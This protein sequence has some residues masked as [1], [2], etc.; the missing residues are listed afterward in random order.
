M[1]GTVTAFDDHVGLG[2]VTADDGTAYL[3]HC[4][5]IADGSRTIA[6]GTRVAFERL[7]KL[8]RYEAADLRPA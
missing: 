2:T 8:G 7:A 4:V 5:E 6:V 3:F 1:H